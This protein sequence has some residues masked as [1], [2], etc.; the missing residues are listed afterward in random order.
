[1]ICAIWE[2][3]VSRIYRT[4][5]PVPAG[6]PGFASCF[7][8]P[9][10]PRYASNNLP[11]QLLRSLVA[12]RKSQLSR[13][14]CTRRCAPGDLDG[15]WWYGQN[16]PGLEVAAELSEVFVDGVFLVSLAPFSDPAWSSPP[17]PKR[18]VSKRLQSTA[19]RPAEALCERNRLLLLLDNFEQVVEAAVQV[20]AVLALCPQLKVPATS[21]G[22][23]HV[24]GEHEFPV[25]PL[26]VPNP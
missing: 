25:P 4:E 12:S 13:T 18:W 6:H 15:P 16:P 3:I 24:R 20:A 23:L 21:R 14:C 2:S 22:V 9:E 11:V 5:P 19:A 10:D 1:M 8:T 7:P 17:S 26:S